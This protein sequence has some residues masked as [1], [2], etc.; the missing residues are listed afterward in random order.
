MLVPSAGHDYPALVVP[1]RR[2]R[3]PGPAPSQE[4]P[5]GSSRRLRS[6]AARWRRDRPLTFRSPE[7]PE[8]RADAGDEGAASRSPTRRVALL[9]SSRVALLTSIGAYGAPSPDG[10]PA[11]SPQP[12][13]AT[14]PARG[15]AAIAFRPSATRRWAHELTVQR[16]IWH[17]GQLA[18]G[19]IAVVADPSGWGHPG[20]A[21]PARR[22]PDSHSRPHRA[23]RGRKATGCGQLGAN[24]PL[25]RGPVDPDGIDSL[26][27]PGHRHPDP[28]DNASIAIVPSTMTAQ[29]PASLRLTDPSETHWQ[30]PLCEPAVS[31]NVMHH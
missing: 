24:R 1:C 31:R 30:V 13:L 23:R 28:T 21:S 5:G 18:A 12:D 11:S 27:R 2:H 8:P 10:S 19:R 15:I 29:S 14:G 7:G 6:R 26:H 17:A 22:T 16:G 3:P 9:T 4:P 20:H 25:L